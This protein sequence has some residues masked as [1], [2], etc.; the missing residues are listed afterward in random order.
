MSWPCGLSWVGMRRSFLFGQPATARAEMELSIQV[1]RT[2]CSGMKSSEPHLHFTGGRIWLGSNG[3]HF[4]SATRTSWQSRQYQTGIG[5]ANILCREM[6]QSHSM[7]SAQ[8]SSRT[9]MCGGI[10][11]I[12][13]AVFLISS[14]L[15]RTNHCCSERI[16]IGVLHRQQS[17]TFCSRG[18]CLKIIPWS[19][20]SSVIFFLASSTERPL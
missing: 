7:E 18:S 5:V 19:R 6:H 17:P 13:S 14:G 11:S 10:H 8:L 16:S 4:S 2:S 1:S 20:I 9:R 3:S 15:I 12:S